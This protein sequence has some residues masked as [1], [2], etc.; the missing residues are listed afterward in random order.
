MSIAT[1]VVAFASLMMSPCVACSDVPAAGGDGG[2]SAT[3]EGDDS[4]TTGVDSTATGVTPTT[5]G[6]T[7]TTTGVDPSGTDSE[8][9]GDEPPQGCVDSDAPWLQGYPIPREDSLPGDP[10]LGL[11]ALLT[12]D[13]VSCGIPWEL[14][15]IA[16]PLL[17]TYADGPSLAW[18]PG[19]NAQVPAGWNVLEMKDG[20]EL[21]SPNC[22]NCH[23]ASSTAS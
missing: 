7:P 21:V 17:G 23:S 8:S 2:S 12:E 22:F 10:V 20:S 6:V 13:Y 15:P 5:T 4:T 9:S 16:Q 11:D 18:R 3:D 19:K 1:R 14:F